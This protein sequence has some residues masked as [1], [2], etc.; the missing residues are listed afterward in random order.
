MIRKLF[1]RHKRFVKFCVV[2][3]ICTS[4]DFLL[5]I[6]FVETWHWPVLLANVFSF[7]ISATTSFF[8]NKYWTFKNKERRFARQMSQF[9]TVA[10]MGLGFSTFFL[11]LFM[12]FN[13]WYVI[14]KAITVVIVVFWNFTVNR[15][16]TFR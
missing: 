5:L 13:L 9:F 11:W 1:K 14:A 10:T 8:L 16:W 15:K 6:L 7:V 2:G 12:S 3:F 4:I